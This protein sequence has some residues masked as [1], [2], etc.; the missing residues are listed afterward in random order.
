M[1]PAKAR[2]VVVLPA[3]VWSDQPQHRA[4]RHFKAE[5]G[6]RR[7]L[8]VGLVVVDDLNEHGEVESGQWRV[9]RDEAKSFNPEPSATETPRQTPSPMAPG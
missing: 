2:N 8:V 1:I 7:Q 6:D 4:R 3:P 5:I 9:E